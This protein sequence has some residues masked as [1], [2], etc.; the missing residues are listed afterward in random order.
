[1]LVDQQLISGRDHPAATPTHGWFAVQDGVLELD[2]DVLV[3]ASVREMSANV[4]PLRAE[5]GLGV[6]GITRVV[7]VDRHEWTGRAQ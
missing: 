4:A 2:N 7:N 5:L 3:S 1:M 6:R